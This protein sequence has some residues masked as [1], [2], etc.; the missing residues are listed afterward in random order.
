MARR[1]LG[2]AADE[3]SDTQVGE[4]LITFKLL[5]NEQLLYTGSKVNESIHELNTPST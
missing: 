5:G 3:L 4:M 1:I 2:T